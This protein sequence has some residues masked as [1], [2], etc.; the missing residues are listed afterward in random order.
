MGELG[1][2]CQNVTHPG[3][4]REMLQQLLETL[5]PTESDRGCMSMAA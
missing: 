2:V 4:Q 1:T 3:L 5:W